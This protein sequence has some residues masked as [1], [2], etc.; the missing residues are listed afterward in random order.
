MSYTPTTWT[1]GDTITATK[2]NKI[3]QGVANA[4]GICPIVGIYCPNSSV[5]YQAVGLDFE[6]ALSMA[7]EGIPFIAYTMTYDSSAGW[8]LSCVSQPL[9]VYYTENYPNRI[10]LQI[11]GGI[12]YYWTANGIEYHD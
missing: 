10:D 6:T 8:F 3:E 12:G 4:G 2:L 9:A 7:Q 11:T 1:T 5:G